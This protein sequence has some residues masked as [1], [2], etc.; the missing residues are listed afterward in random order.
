MAV[1]AGCSISEMGRRIPSSEWPLFTSLYAM[2][3][4]GYEADNY[5]AAMVAS[6]VANMAG[7]SLKSSCKIED[8]LTP[9]PLTEKQQKLL[10]EAQ[11]RYG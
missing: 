9:K 5:H 11:Q 7:K 3:P 10:D 1:G 2:E 4:W 8:Y 6:T